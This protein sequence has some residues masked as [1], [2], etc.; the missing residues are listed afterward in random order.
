ME[1]AVKDQ[2]L[3]ALLNSEMTFTELARTISRPNR[4]IYVNLKKLQDQGFVVKVKRGLYSLTDK[5]GKEA[6]K[7]GIQRET[8]V[9][10]SAEASDWHDVPDIKK[11]VERRLYLHGSCLDLQKPRGSTEIILSAGMLPIKDLIKSFLLLRKPEKE[12]LRFL[13]EIFINSPK[14]YLG[15]KSNLS[16][17][18]LRAAWQAVKPEAW[19]EREMREG[20]EFDFPTAYRPARKRLSQKLKNIMKERKIDQRFVFRRLHAFSFPV[21]ERMK[22]AKENKL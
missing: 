15:K 10:D 21:R 12:Y 3:C 13:R 4:T 9:I 19:R 8:Q 22:L 17:F 16:W 18:D 2:I 14:K 1:R 11:Q 7:V 6:E 20:L 5:G